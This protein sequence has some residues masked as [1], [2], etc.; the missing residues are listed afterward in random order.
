M[1]T[2]CNDFSQKFVLTKVSFK[3]RRGGVETEM[4]KFL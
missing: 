1:A 3:L 2:M 4:N